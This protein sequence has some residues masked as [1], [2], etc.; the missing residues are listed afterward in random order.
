ML[1]NVFE[2]YLQGDLTVDRAEGGLGIG[3]TIVK[4]LVEL[5]GGHVEAKSAGLGMGSDFLVYLP[6]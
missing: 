2:P 3:L 4:H 1:P 5:H 6:R